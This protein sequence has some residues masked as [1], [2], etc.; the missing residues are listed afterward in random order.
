MDYIHVGTTLQK[1]NRKTKTKSNKVF[2][3]IK[4][5][6]VFLHKHD[7]ET[8]Q[9]FIVFVMPLVKQR[10]SKNSASVIRWKWNTLLIK[11]FIKC[12]NTCEKIKRKKSFLHLRNKTT[13]NFFLLILHTTCHLRFF[14]RR[15]KS[16]EQWPLIIFLFFYVSSLRKNKK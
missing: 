7:N 8:I 4:Q 6:G 9:L 1:Q 14:L 10:D 13:E 12:N 5:K 15:L 11:L 3:C 2:S 16:P